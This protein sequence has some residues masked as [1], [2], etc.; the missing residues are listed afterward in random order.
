MP[1]TSRSGHG[2]R[3]DSAKLDAVQEYMERQV[4]QRTAKDMDVQRRVF[5]LFGRSATG[6]SLQLFKHSLHQSFGV[7]LTEAEA[8]ELF[9]RYD[10]NNNGVVSLAEFVRMVMP[11][12]YPGGEAAQQ[13][14]V[15][16]G[17]EIERQV[18]P[19]GHD[20]LEQIKSLRPTL[21]E[22]PAA[23]AQVKPDL[24]GYKQQLLDKILERTVRPSEMYRRAY[25]LFGA[26][27]DGLTL[28]NFRVRL[29][30]LGIV[31]TPEDSQAFF[32]SIDEDGSGNIDFPELVKAL[33]P[34][35]FA[36]GLWTEQRANEMF[37][38]LGKKDI[39]EPV[40]T[41]VPEA[42]KMVKHS[43]DE[44][45]EEIGRRILMRTKRPEDQ[46]REAYRMFGSPH[47]GVSFAEFKKHVSLL[48]LVV[49]DKQLKDVFDIIDEDGSG[50]IDFP[51]MM[52]N[53]MGQDYTEPTWTEKRGEETAKGIIDTENKWE[54]PILKEWPKALAR[55]RMTV[56]E[57]E[58]LVQHKLFERVKRPSDQYR[59]AY[60]LFGSPEGGISL[61]E[62]K[63]R[64]RGFGL[65]LSDA[66]VENM[67]HAYDLNKNGKLEFSELVK[68][69]MTPDYPHELWNV[70][71]DVEDREKEEREKH[72]RIEESPFGLE[73]I[74]GWEGTKTFA[75]DRVRAPIDA[76]QIEA[77][78]D[79]VAALQAR[80]AAEREAQA[81]YVDDVRAGRVKPRA[82]GRRKVAASTKPMRATVDL[83]ALDELARKK[84]GARPPTTPGRV[85]SASFK[86][87]RH[88]NKSRS[89]MGKTNLSSSLRKPRTGGIQTSGD[90][91]LQSIITTARQPFSEATMQFAAVRNA[92]DP[93]GNN[94]VG[95]NL[96]VSSAS[97][98]V[99][100]LKARRRDH[101]RRTSRGR[102]GATADGPR[103]PLATSALTIGQPLAGPSAA[104]GAP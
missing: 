75:V 52:R 28:S 49:T 3:V 31:M 55:H 5:Q 65:V 83:K 93:A 11:K 70:R 67:F 69:V 44:I 36:P 61:D 71:R 53:I 2:E 80:R 64:L 62:L 14:T 103:G 13:W 21:T 34:E 85:R 74:P 81:K 98:L 29:D 76:G 66:E 90:I 88:S 15:K 16:R 42:L 7:E 87:M 91:D 4:Q 63:F 24:E 97:S 86:P 79:D 50:A 40:L 57:I 23:F 37:K 6:L 94:P 35:D 17:A 101:E 41:E 8:T 82:I 77:D 73:K 92:A 100:E 56:H 58:D 27:H 51:E 46:Y 1:R 72:I 96:G 22:Y 32:D 33:M 48:G 38:D 26:P 102:S 47:D 20:K 43:N 95:G 9:R 54:E 99:R 30:R 104:V 25:K 68:H 78:P 18:L 45:R 60:A 19:G 89:G 39:Q 10:R 84:L 12:D 59:L